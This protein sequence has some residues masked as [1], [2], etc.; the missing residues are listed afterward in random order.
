MN[1]A[2]DKTRLENF[3]PAPNNNNN[4]LTDQ[5]ER[6]SPLAVIN[7]DKASALITDCCILTPFYA[8][9]RRW[10]SSEVDLEVYLGY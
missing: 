5:D 7:D 4:K 1:H 3:A 8:H 2:T 6:K 9:R 10:A